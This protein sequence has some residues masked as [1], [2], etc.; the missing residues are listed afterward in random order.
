VALTI[1]FVDSQSDMTA[2]EKV[3]KKFISPRDFVLIHIPAPRDLGEVMKRMEAH[4][5]SRRFEP[6]FSLMEAAAWYAFEYLPSV[7]IA[8][9]LECRFSTLGKI[10]SQPICRALVVDSQRERGLSLN[11]QHMIAMPSYCSFPAMSL[12]PEVKEVLTST[13]L[14]GSIRGWKGWIDSHG[15]IKK[16]LGK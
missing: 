11:Y 16:R 9:A 14:K 8:I 4:E 1:A 6:P 5:P 10:A 13:T 3:L 7:D 12:V 15:G 2:V